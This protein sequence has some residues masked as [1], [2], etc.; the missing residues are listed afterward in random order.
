MTQTLYAFLSIMIVTM[1][2][3]TQRSAILHAQLSAMR[4]D[5][6]LIGVGV[7]VEQLDFIATRPFDAN[8][9]VS[10]PSELTSD[11]D[12]GLGSTSFMT[13]TDID[14]FHGKTLDVNIPTMISTLTFDVSVQVAYVAKS[15][16]YYVASGT[17]TYFKEVTVTV[18]GEVNSQVQMSR[19]LAYN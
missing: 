4:S 19:I 8:D 1:F 10:D 9:P 13:S 6:D 14:D 18:G 15:G 2:S 3:L 12:F 5:V 7:A 11:S 17:Q 16:G